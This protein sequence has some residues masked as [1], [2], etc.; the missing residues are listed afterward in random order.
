MLFS[1]I[2]FGIL[3][4]ISGFLMMKNNSGAFI[5]AFISGAVTLIMTLGLFYRIQ[6]YGELLELVPLGYYLIWTGAIGI[7]I[8]SV[9]SA[10]KS[11]V[12]RKVLLLLSLIFSSIVAVVVL[13]IFV[14]FLIL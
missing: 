6:F 4:T 5:F 14:I 10:I 1:P 9:I 2:L 11:E 8:G 7:I 13:I 3:G 12:G